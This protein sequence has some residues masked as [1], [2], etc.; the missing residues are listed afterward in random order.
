MTHDKGP[1]NQEIHKFA[2][3]T[4]EKMTE[5]AREYGQYGA[6]QDLLTDAFSADAAV[7][8][9]LHES[10]GALAGLARLRDELFDVV[11]VT[12]EP[13]EALALGR[14]VAVMRE[15]VLEQVGSPEELRARPASAFVAEFLR[16]DPL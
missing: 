2:W 7:E 4:F 15:G 3:D 9:D 5:V 1:D 11:L 8:V 13:G 14:R 16:P 6:G 12:H 10:V